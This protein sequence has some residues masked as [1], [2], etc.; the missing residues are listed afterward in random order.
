MSC[1]H[2]TRCGNLGAGYRSRMACRGYRR[3][4][5]SLAEGAGVPALWAAA[6]AAADDGWGCVEV[7]NEGS[8]PS[9]RPHLLEN[10]SGTL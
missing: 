10:A 1:G 2:P 8:T 3:Y 4:A 6:A 7:C 9:E 5:G